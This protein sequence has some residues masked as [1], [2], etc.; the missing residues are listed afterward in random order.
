MFRGVFWDSEGVC[1]LYGR[2]MIVVLELIGSGFFSSRGSRDGLKVVLY[3]DLHVSVVRPSVCVLVCPRGFTLLLLPICRRRPNTV[4]EG[5]VSNS[6]CG[7]LPALE[8]PNPKSIRD[9]E[10]DSKVTPGN[11]AQSDLKVTQK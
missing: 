8:P 5:T 1:F 10:S 3:L 9:S 11:R 7:W 6:A 4:L 2:G